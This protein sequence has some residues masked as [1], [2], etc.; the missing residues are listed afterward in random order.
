MYIY[1][2]IGPMT[3][4]RAGAAH[5][6]LTHYLLDL[7]SGSSG[8]TDPFSPVWITA[9]QNYSHTKGQSGS[10]YRVDPFT[11]HNAQELKLPIRA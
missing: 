5:R 1:I 2:Y 7:H 3:Y 9:S 4:P 11:R 6:R 8:A 10:F